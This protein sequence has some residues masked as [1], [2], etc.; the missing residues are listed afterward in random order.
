[1]EKDAEINSL[2]DHNLTTILKCDNCEKFFKTKKKLNTHITNEHNEK[3]KRIILN[4]GA[5][6]LLIKRQK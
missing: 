2:K 4:F 3:L 5:A 1:M 6:L